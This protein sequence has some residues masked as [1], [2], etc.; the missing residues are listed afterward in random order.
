[1]TPGPRTGRLNRDGITHT[2][3]LVL[4]AWG[5]FLYGFG[6]LLPQLGRDQG[7]SRTVTGLHSLAL[8]TGGLIAGWFAVPLVRALHRRGVLRLGG[9]LVITGCLLLCLGGAFTWASLIS[10][11]VIG[12]GGSLMVNTANPTLADHHHE[13]GAA[14]LSEGNAV[15]A[16]CGLVAPLVV[17][18]G[19]ALGLSWR[20][21]MLLTVPLV[22]A[23]LLVLR[24]QPL[25]SV[26]LDTQLPPRHQRAAKLPRAFWP[27]SGMLVACVGVEFCVANW[28][29]DLLREQVGLSAAT[30][31][32]GVSAVVGGMTLGRVGTG[33]LALRHPPRQ[34]LLI[35][36]GL[37]L[38]GWLW[39]WLSLTGWA[40]LIALFVTGLGLGAHYPIGAS[41][42][43]ASAD[44]QRDQAAGVLSIGIAVAAGGSP[45]A[46]G[47]L[48]DATSTHT[49]F[50]VVPVLLV[51]AVLLLALSAWMAREPGIAGSPAVQS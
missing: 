27:A 22:I 47:A 51:A 17:G 45:F 37:S 16:S 3:Y 42:V 14:A 41:I 5:W 32:A 12:T 31:A 21:A 8:A 49:A 4:A 38:V 39:L 11:L 20:P 48:A 50:L 24:R 19:V 9:G 40:A 23:M 30:A 44:R 35:A 18:G 2:G 6:A 43:F 33:R 29:A 25:G 13:H 28:S 34:L 46:L 26:A 1:L 36:L 10:V 15:A 7:V